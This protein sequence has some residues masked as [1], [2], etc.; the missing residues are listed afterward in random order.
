MSTASRLALVLVAVCSLGNPAAA[1][2][3]GSSAPPDEEVAFDGGSSTAPGAPA[4]STYYEEVLAARGAASAPARAAAAE[5]TGLPG[6][7]HVVPAAGR[8]S[9]R[10]VRGERWK[11][12]IE[13][14]ARPHER[15][16]AV[17]DLVLA[18]ALPADFR[19]DTWRLRARE[20]RRGASAPA[21]YA[22]ERI[23]LKRNRALE[24]SWLP[25]LAGARDGL[26]DL[27]GS[28]YAWTL[29]DTIVR[30]DAGAGPELAGFTSLAYTTDRRTP[31][32]QAGDPRSAAYL[33]SWVPSLGPA[34]APYTLRIDASEPG[35][36]GRRRRAQR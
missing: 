6:A 22:G 12:S 20:G 14:D 23:R 29:W 9:Y 17:Y 19:S 8:V 1:F 31:V 2:D 11:V 4:A 13:V 5:E 7:L 26:P 15:V 30:Y 10:R 34:V 24:A 16:D 32:P 3:G 21:R 35:E 18:L 33:I 27:S 28:G 25:R 36:E